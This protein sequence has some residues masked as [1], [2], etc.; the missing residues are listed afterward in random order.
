ME[1][2]CVGLGRMEEAF[3]RGFGPL[4]IQLRHLKPE[5][6]EEIEHILFSTE[7]P[8]QERFFKGR[9]ID[10]RK[11]DIELWPTEAQIC[12]GH[13]MG[14]LCV[15]DRAETNIPGLYAAGDVASVP[16]QHLS[17]AFVF[18]EIAAEEAVEFIG[19]NPDV[20]LNGHQI[21]EVENLRNR[22]FSSIDRD[23]DIRELEYKVR[24]LIGDYVISPKNEYKL[25]RWLEWSERF[26]FEI[27][28]RVAVRNGHELSKLYEVEHI[29][30]CADFSALSSL[31]RKESRWGD[32]HYRVD[33]PDKDD[34]NW[35]CHVIVQK[36]DYRDDIQVGT[37]PVTDSDGKEVRA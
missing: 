33:Y 24:R 21:S 13:G 6:I 27:N 37:K 9:A 29:V 22:R 23:I 5:I 7:R 32:A 16:K 34:K 3:N 31:E 4:R 30:R 2:E 26:N 10:F 17:G 18:G 12:G 20:K 19:S 35:C 11:R 36:G 25:N 1:N 28:N 15:N 8:V 14:G